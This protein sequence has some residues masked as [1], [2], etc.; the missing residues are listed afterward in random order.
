MPHDTV[1]ISIRRPTASPA[2]VVAASF[3]DPAW[4]PVELTA[5]TVAGKDE[6]AAEEYEFSRTFKVEEGKHQYKFRLEGEEEWFC[7]EGG[8]TGGFDFFLTYYL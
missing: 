2:I 1:K 6:E 7:D 5:E 4:D 3:T 8:E